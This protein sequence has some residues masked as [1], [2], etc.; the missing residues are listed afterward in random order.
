MEQ[1]QFAIEVLD[2]TDPA[3]TRRVCRLL[4]GGSLGMFTLPFVYLSLEL[5]VLIAA[6]C[7]VVI[8]TPWW[9]ALAISLPGG[10]ALHVATVWTKLMLRVGIRQGDH[11]YVLE[12]PHG[13]AFGVVKKRKG[14]VFVADAA[15]ESRA[16]SRQLRLA[17]SQRTGKDRTREHFILP[18]A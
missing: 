4:R 10:Y 8:D 1:P 7:L 15:A 12:S 6:F 5:A 17:V 14:T 3:A 11:W 2:A 9:V 18:P 16:L 13:R